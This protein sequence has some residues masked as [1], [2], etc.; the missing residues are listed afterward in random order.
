[1]L[2]GDDLIDEAEDLLT[3]MMDG[4]QKTGGSVI[5]LIE[6]DPSQISATAARTSRRW[7]ARTLSA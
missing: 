4:Q 6:V 3:T 5:A 7:T 2:L 1:M